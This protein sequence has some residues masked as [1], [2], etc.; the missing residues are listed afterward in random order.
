MPPLQ[1]R[2][3]SGFVLLTTQT[4]PAP[5]SPHRSQAHVPLPRPRLLPLLQ[6]A[7]VADFAMTLWLGLRVGLARLPV[8]AV[9]L[10]LARPVAVGVVE[11]SRNVR[12]YG[13]VII[14]Q[15][16]ASAVILTWRRLEKLTLF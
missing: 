16:M 15:V 11:S 12:Q 1:T 14:G 9:V 3:D 6:L 5:V 8:S 10:N 7:A 4:S 2:S 13:P